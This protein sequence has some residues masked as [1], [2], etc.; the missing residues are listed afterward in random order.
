MHTVLLS[1]VSI[2]Y[3]TVK[4][5]LI[6]GAE[7]DPPPP[8]AGDGAAAH[9]Q[10]PT[11]L[12]ANVIALPTTNAAVTDPVTVNEYHDGPGHDERPDTATAALA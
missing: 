6:A 8:S 7:S 3:R 5:I 9:L 11:Q 2:R 12:F 1:I 4:G 10:G